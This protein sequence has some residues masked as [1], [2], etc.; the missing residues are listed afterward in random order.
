MR[1][2]TFL[3][4]ATAL[5]G[6]ASAFDNEVT[7]DLVSIDTSSEFVTGLPGNR[8]RVNNDV[9]TRLL[10]IGVTWYLAPVDD[11][12]G[13]RS[14]APFLSKSS[15][16][17][18]NLGLGR[19]DLS[20]STLVENPGLPPSQP[21]DIDTDLLSTGAQG[22]YVWAD[23]GW[24]VTAAYSRFDADTD[25][26][27]F[28]ADAW[29]FGAGFY[30]G[31]RTALHMQYLDGE[32]SDDGTRSGT[33]SAVGLSLTHIGDLGGDWEYGTD[34]GLTSQDRA[35]SNGAWDLRLSL[36]PSRD[37]AFGV[38]VASTFDGAA[39]DVVSYELFGGWYPSD[40]IGLRAGYR[41][42]DFPSSDGADVE[43]DGFSLGM[44]VRF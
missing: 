44:T 5:P 42:V 36:Y 30:I 10:D 32:V 15:S 11:S 34:V 24:F 28:S 25:D 19:S 8:I 16:L 27:G 4:I 38:D 7:A 3:I 23:T 21:S 2:T 20:A 41:F 9:D 26:R 37:L 40:S 31:D 39:S 12:R 22:R 43:E 33:D 18:V 29:S 1:C 35:D 6:I 17:A 14:R 13:P